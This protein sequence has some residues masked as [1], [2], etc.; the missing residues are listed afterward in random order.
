MS[1]V[2]ISTRNCCAAD[3]D[4]SNAASGNVPSIVRD[5]SDLNSRGQSH[6]RRLVGSMDGQRV[7][8]H[9][10][11]GFGHPIGGDKWRSECSRDGSGEFI[12]KR[13]AA[14]ADE[15]K[16]GR[17]GARVVFGG[18]VNENAVNRGYGGVPR[19]SEPEYIWPKQVSRETACAW[20]IGAAATRQSCQ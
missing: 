13:C 8:R 2:E 1:I 15:T 14:A 11:R 9:L 7:R 19:H 10:M 4:F 17:S 5:N 18:T 20:Q 3:Q 6:R 16:L 12:V